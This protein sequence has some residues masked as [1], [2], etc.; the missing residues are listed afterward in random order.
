MN[1]WN[2]WLNWHEQVR[3]PK[4]CKSNFT[5]RERQIS[6]NLLEK[7]NTS[8]QSL[9]KWILIM[10]VRW[11]P[12]P[13]TKW[14]D[15]IQCHLLLSHYQFDNVALFHAPVVST[16]QNILSMKFSIN[17]KFVKINHLIE[18]FIFI[19]S[20]LQFISLLTSKPAI[21]ALKLVRTECDYVI[22]NLSLLQKN[23]P[24]HVKLEE[25]ESMQ[26]NQTSTVSSSIFLSR[27]WTERFSLLLLDTYV[28]D[29][30]VEK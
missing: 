1:V 17:S 30:H 18:I 15:P 14:L 3:H 8:H 21:D 16:Y 28:F 19:L 4:L 25:F 7:M 23:I 2:A 10:L 20:L 24:K 6:F 26:V 22:N 11:I 27:H 9:K 5:N 29:G 12:W 13:S